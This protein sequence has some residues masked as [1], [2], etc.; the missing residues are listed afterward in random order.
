MMA[1]EQPYIVLKTT[2]RESFL[3]TTE[4]HELIGKSSN[5]P[6]EFIETLWEDYSIDLDNLNM[7]AEERTGKHQI[8]A[9]NDGKEDGV[10]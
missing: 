9:S 2:I 8:T 1:K 3:G 5:L 7:R 4:T 6:E 10:V